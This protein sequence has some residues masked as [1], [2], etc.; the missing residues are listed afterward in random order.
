MWRTRVTSIKQHIADYC[1]DS[2][3]AGVKYVVAKDRPLFERT[4]WMVAITCSFLWSMY[5]IYE[6]WDKWNNS[7]VIISFAEETTPVWRIPFPAITI[8]SRNKA[9]QSIFNFSKLIRTKVYEPENITEDEFE[10]TLILEHLCF[11]QQA[12]LDLYMPTCVSP[13]MNESMI[14]FLE[15]V[16][17]LQKEFFSYCTWQ[18]AMINCT[19]LLTPIMTEE[20]YCF[21]TNS[22]SHSE[23]YHKDG[24]NSKYLKSLPNATDWDLDRGYYNDTGPL[25]ESYPRRAISSGTRFGLRIVIYVDNKDWD[26]D[27][28]G[29]FDGFTVTMHNPAEVASV[30]NRFFNVPR[31][32]EVFLAVKPQHD[33]N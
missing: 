10:K 19:Q 29:L 21:T 2:T 23:L 30:S 4:W 25:H 28:M 3:L 8:C 32:Q 14:D 22:L 31:D 1:E 16:A 6:V 18:K 27:C 5:L 33:D 11:N 17:G 7:P 20:G 26:D 15:E 24:L 12:S 13:L 9:R